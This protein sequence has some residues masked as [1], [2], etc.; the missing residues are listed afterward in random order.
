MKRFG[1]GRFCWGKKSSFFACKVHLRKD[2][3]VLDRS[4]ELSE[5]QGR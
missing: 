5:M 4:V 1:L 2:L 3:E